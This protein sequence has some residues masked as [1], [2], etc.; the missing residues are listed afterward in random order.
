MLTIL[1]VLC[2][3]QDKPLGTDSPKPRL[4]WALQAEKRNV[5]Q[6]A[7]RIQ[8]SQ[9]SDFSGELADTGT[10]TS[11][12]S[13]HVDIPDTLLLPS[14]RYFYRVMVSSDDSSSEWKESWFETGRLSESNWTA[15]WITCPSDVVSSE[16][17][18]RFRKA[19]HLDGKQIKSARLYATA[20]G[21]YEARLN[22]KRIGDMYLAPGWT[23][24]R[25][26]LLYQSYDVTEL[27]QEDNV[28][29]FT[30]GK[31]WYQGNLG[32]SGKKN[33]YGEESTFLAE[34]H[35]QNEDGEHIIIPTD[36]SWTAGAS[37]ILSSEIYHGETYDARLEQI[38]WDQ[39]GF[40]ETKWFPVS[41]AKKPPGKLAAQEHEPVRKHE[42]FKPIELITTPKG[43]TVLDFGQNMVGWV[44]FKVKGKRG[45]SVSLYHFEVLDSDGNVYLDNLRQAKQT[46]TYIL[47]GG[48]KEAYEPHFSFQGFRYVQLVDFPKELDLED[49]TGVVLH[50]DMRRT[51]HFECSNELLNQLQHNIIWGQKGNFVDVPTDCPQRDER[52]GWT[53]DAQMF[54][55][56]AAYLYNVAPFFT[57]WLRDLA[58]E[59]G[60]DGSVPFVIPHVDEF[61]THSS[62]A[63]GDA[64]VICPWVLYEQYG[65]VRI[66][67]EQFESMK[68][69][70]NY[71]HQQGEHPF[72]WNTGFHFG[73]WLALD[74]QPGSY[75]GA[76]ERDFIATAFYAYS[77]HLVSKAARVLKR[78]ADVSH[79]EELYAS[80]KEAFLTEFVTDSGRLAVPTQTAH[81]LAITF[82]LLEGTS[83]K[84]AEQK[85]KQLMNDSKYHLTT[86][87]VGTPYLNFALTKAGLDD[88]AFTLLFQE[89]YP[90]W[91]YQVKKGATTVW[92]HWD[93]IRE[94][95]SFWSKDMNSFNHYAYGSIGDWLYRKV[96]GIDCDS[97][98]PGYKRIHFE[99]HFTENLS[100]V[101]S[102]LDTMYGL[103]AS[104]WELH[105]DGNIT[106]KVT[107]PPNTTGLLVFPTDDIHLADMDGLVHILEQNYQQ[108]I[109][110]FG[111]GDYSFS[112]KPVELTSILKATDLTF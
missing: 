15:N 68:A 18:P 62:A 56:T 75:I 79:Y 13:V 82:D 108:T 89:D 83:L 69:W 93:G 10:I 35:L 107:I 6:T 11:E 31:G 21:L 34:L 102:S 1:H 111:S 38:G 95:G 37:P 99:P 46:N 104:S 41:I 66:L 96:A 45:Q 81:V 87:F 32:W 29:S 5:K 106:W 77:T 74:S 55:S 61:S 50:S 33:I 73:D 94:D 53:G 25:D 47:K 20:T 86:G 12:Q 54:I 98:A 91:L 103:T 100:W 26:R 88:I 105:K 24:Y 70:V 72:L 112:F 109:A 27:I 17:S 52:M 4:S 43:E 84:R 63:W 60:D 28:L 9:Q 49:F 97:T 48:E 65:D 23:N 57:K 85:L 58:S 36:S 2:D 30:I 71:I 110:E 80:I 78:E 64:A 76:T 51:G 39:P 16:Q 42:H 8:V 40:D 67:E 14:T 90:S 7:Y 92:E 19:F 3:Y 44:H 101:K 22:G 59:Q